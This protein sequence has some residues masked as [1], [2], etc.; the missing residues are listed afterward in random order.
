MERDDD[1]KKSHPALTANSAFAAEAQRSFPQRPAAPTSV[2]R[3]AA[4][5]GKRPAQDGL[6]VGPKPFAE[7]DFSNDPPT[8]A[9]IELP[10][11]FDDGLE[12]QMARRQGAGP[13]RPSLVI[14]PTHALVAQLDRASDFESE[15]RE[16]ESLRA[17]QAH[18]RQASFT[19][20]DRRHDIKES[21]V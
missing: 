8:E 11:A 18:L 15:G 14:E 12:Q 20:A 13:A 4:R 1:S 3:K 17:R 2:R 9:G 6:S 16:F 21:P 10:G 19:I 5:P 7:M